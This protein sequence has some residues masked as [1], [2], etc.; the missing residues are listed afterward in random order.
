MCSVSAGDKW[1]QAEEMANK[2]SEEGGCDI[3]TGPEKGCLASQTEKLMTH[4]KLAT[5]QRRTFI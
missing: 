2:G 1:C 4:E 5:I 3:F